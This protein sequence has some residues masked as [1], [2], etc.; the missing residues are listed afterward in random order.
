MSMHRLALPLVLALVA[1]PLDAQTPAQNDSAARAA[2][3]T[4][5][6]PLATP[7]TLSFTTDEATW[8]SL[9]VSPDG[10]TIVFDILGDL[11]TLPI[12]GGTATRITSGAGWDQQPRYSPDGK[13]IAFVS[14][15]NGSKNVWIANADG[16][17]PRILTRSER[18]N[19]ASPIW[20]SDCQYVIAT[21]AFKLWMFNYEGGS[22]IQLT[23]LRPEG[24]AAPAGPGA[25]TPSHYSAARSGDDRYVWVNVTG[26]VAPTLA[27]G[28]GPEDI[29]SARD[30]MEE[31]AA[32]SNARRLG[33]YQIAQFDRETGRTLLRTHETDGAFRP[34]ASPD[35]KW[36]V[37]ATRYDARAALKARDLTTGEEHWLVMDVQ[38]D[39][40]Q[41]GGMNDRDVY[42]GSAF[43]PDSRSLITSFKGKIWKVE[44]PS[45]AVSPIPFSA[46]VEQTMGPLAKFDYPVNDSTLVVTQIR[47]AKPSPDGRLLAF[48][49]LDALYVGEFPPAPAAGDTTRQQIRNLKKLTTGGMVEHA[50][51]WSPDGRYIAYATWTD[52][53]GGNIYRVRSDGSSPAERLTRLAAFYDKIN[54]TKD[55]TRIF[56]ARGSRYSRMRQFEDFGNLANAELEYVWSPSGGGDATRI[57]WAGSGQSQQGRNEPHVGPD[58]TRLYVWAGNEGLVS[59]R[60]D[61][62]DRK[63]VVRVS[64]PPPPAQP[65]P[66]GATPPPPPSPDEVLLAP[67][68]KRAL[69]LANNNVYVIAVPPVVGQAPAV[70]VSGS[71]VPASRLTRVGGDFIGW[72]SDSRTAFYSIGKSYFQYD[73]IAAEAAIRDSVARADSI[74]AAAHTRGG[75]GCAGAGAGH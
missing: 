48:T 11:Y 34:V 38:R 25:A 16:T 1:L 65:L 18:I 47:G 12:T 73:V 70:A 43:T 22:G 13:Q 41:G 55:G 4:N 56:A 50:P 37:Y 33:Q 17:R 60:L 52:T 19:F 49:A 9:D 57:A 63:V 21:R 2:T 6:L 36:L 29:Q 69:V 42:P 23:G 44:V 10:K 53:A 8:I 51:V 75:G 15:R 68:G 31:A 45:G 61:G 7:R 30:E 66:P 39:N 28:F 32:R 27:S 26:F 14:D 72:S 58:S 24:A 67:D 20:S 54:Y 62:T 5:T 74:A 64:S 46:Q 35:G 59:M 71:S 40:S 3:R